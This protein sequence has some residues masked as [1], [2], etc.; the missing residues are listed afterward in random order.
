MV[1]EL[2]EAG[3]ETAAGT[4]VKSPRILAARAI[5]ECSKRA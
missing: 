2:A 3:L 1:G 5:R 4:H